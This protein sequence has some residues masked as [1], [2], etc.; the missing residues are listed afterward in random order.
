MNERGHAR[1]ARTARGR[2]HRRLIAGP[3]IASAL[4]TGCAMLPESAPVRVHTIDLAPP[5]AVRPCAASFSIREL[6][7]PGYLERAEVVTG[8]RASELLLSQSDVWGAPLAAELQRHLGQALLARWVGSRIVHHPWRF[9]ELPGMAIVV[10]IDRLDPVDG[11]LVARARWTI[12]EPGSRSQMLD[13]GQFNQAIAMT[14]DAAGPASATARAIGVALGRLA[15][16]IAARA[17]EVA[18]ASR[19]ARAP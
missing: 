4:L 14:G 1:A 10:D 6:R 15:D 8:R 9:G 2:T 18:L 17:Q 5:Q 11:R 13:N 3:M 12:V 19:C 16:Q 7:L